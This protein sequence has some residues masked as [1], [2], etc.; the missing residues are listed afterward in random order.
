M[1]DVVTTCVLHHPM[2]PVNCL[3]RAL[4][5]LDSATKREHN[6][7]VIVQGALMGGVEL[8]DQELFENIRLSYIHN[9]K[10][11]GNAVPLIHSKERFIK[12]D[13][14]WW[15]K[16]DD[17]MSFPEGS[18]DRAIEAL[19]TEEK[20]GEY[21]CG[22]AMIA[23]PASMWSGVPRIFWHETRCNR[24]PLLRWKSS[25]YVCRDE[26]KQP[27]YTVCDFAD[28]GCTVFKR[29]VLEAGCAPDERLFTGG[30]DFDVC[31]QMLEKGFKSIHVSDPRSSHHHDECKPYRYGVIRYDPNQTR[32]AGRLLMEKWGVEIEL[33]TKFT[34]LSAFMPPKKRRELS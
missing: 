14:M 24:V 19:E 5:S 34:G 2:R 27:R 9:E 31:F 6:V 13:H 25:G 1:R 33:L 10:N 22:C 17:D 23:V 21:N 26:G 28:H 11:L 12:T 30:C 32:R 16:C 3:M 29:A 4:V 18:W 7:E 15:A 20:L 8:P